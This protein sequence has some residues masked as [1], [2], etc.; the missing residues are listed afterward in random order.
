MLNSMNMYYLSAQLH[1][2]LIYL[3][4]FFKKKYV[5]LCCGAQGLYRILYV[6]TYNWIAHYP[7]ATY[8]DKTIGIGKTSKVVSDTAL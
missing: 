3:I 1:T 4:H 5:Y 7:C 8:G 2:N 6:F